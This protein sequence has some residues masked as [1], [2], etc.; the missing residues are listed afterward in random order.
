M[1]VPQRRSAKRFL[2][3]QTILTYDKG[4]HHSENMIPMAQAYQEASNAPSLAQIGQKL[5]ELGQSSKRWSFGR[6]R[7]VQTIIVWSKRSSFG[8]NDLE[9]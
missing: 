3:F 5:K 1:D 4:R 8:P 2:F 7:L 6:N 9:Q